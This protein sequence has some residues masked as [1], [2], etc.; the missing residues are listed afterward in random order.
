MRKLLT[1]DAHGVIR[2]DGLRPGA[3][4]ALVEPETDAEHAAYLRGIHAGREEERDAQT[5]SS[6]TG[7]DDC[8]CRYARLCLHPS[9][10]RPLPVEEGIEIPDWCPLRNAA[11]RIELLREDTCND[12]ND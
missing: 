1:V 12:C 11:L 7:C 6:V 4:M 8:P 9:L 2:V 3:H 10:E 5:L